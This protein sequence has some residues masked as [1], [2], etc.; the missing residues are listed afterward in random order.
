M[1]LQKKKKK[2]AKYSDLFS[3]IFSQNF[4]NFG[5]KQLIL[6]DFGKMKKKRKEKIRKQKIWVCRTH[7]TGLPNSKVWPE[8]NTEVLLQGSPK[9]SV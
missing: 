1:F 3:K 8:T 6:Q 5:Q 4:K 7:K 9:F 2:I